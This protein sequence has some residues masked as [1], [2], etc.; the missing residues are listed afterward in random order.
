M[1]RPKRTRDGE[2]KAAELVPDSVHFLEIF[3]GNGGLTKAVRRLNLK[4]ADPIDIAAGHDVTKPTTL[5][6]ILKAIRERRIRWL[7]LAPPCRSYSVARRPQHRLRSRRYPGGLPN[8]EYN[9]LVIEGNACAR[10]TARMAKACFRAGVFFTIENPKTS[11]IWKM[12]GLA[13]LARIPNVS[14]FVGDQCAFGA[15]S[16]KPTKWLTNAPFA[17]IL[18]ARAPGTSE[19]HAHI[20]LEGKGKDPEDGKWKAKTEIAAAYPTELCDSLA[21]A[22]HPFSTAPFVD[23]PLVRFERNRVIDE[24]VP[25]SERKHERRQADDSAI[26]GLRRAGRAL[27]H[28]PGWKAVGEKARHILD[29]VLDKN[30][31]VF[32]NLVKNLGTDGATDIPEHILQEAGRELQ[33]AFGATDSP[34]MLDKLLREAGD[35]DLEIPEWLRTFAP[36]GLKREIRPR[37]VFP[38]MTATERTRQQNGYPAMVPERTPFRNYAAFDE[39]K[40]AAE[41][42]FAKEIEEGF[43]ETTPRR[44]EL[45]KKY[46]KV[47]LSRIAAIVKE[48]A[49]KVK[50]RLVH[51]LSRSGVNQQVKVPERVVLP[52]AMDI[53]DSAA[54]LM[55]KA[56]PEETLSGMVLDFRSAFKQLRVHPDER[57]FLG[58]VLGDVFFV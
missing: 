45:T 17:S 48:S 38:I 40:E 11:L 41:A 24:A 46:G 19:G 5:K 27:E 10:V 20:T 26:G 29:N 51:D 21:N 2:P 25:D 47:V 53:L 37:G 4:A 34:S 23:I 15:A 28:L 13:A 43:V 52:R 31:G 14:E 35:P 55:E 1:P 44:D 22:F 8:L 6:Q 18:A 36:L 54:R 7:H 12:P 30:A 56:G 16:Q 39:N 57:R 42:E 9:K 3:S 50:C 49:G 33:G 32:D 58:G